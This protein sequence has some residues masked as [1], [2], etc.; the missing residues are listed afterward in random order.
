MQNLNRYMKLGP[1]LQSWKIRIKFEIFHFPF[2][3]FRF[4]LETITFSSQIPRDINFDPIKY[5]KET[6]LRVEYACQINFDPLA[7]RFPFSVLK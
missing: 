2:V 3:M 4:R 1:S 6:L 5:V 7:R